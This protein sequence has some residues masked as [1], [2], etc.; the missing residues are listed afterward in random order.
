MLLFTRTLALDFNKGTKDKMKC[1]EVKDLR[2]E[3]EKQNQLFSFHLHTCSSVPLKVPTEC[4]P[5]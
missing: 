2:H 1:T 3:N 4:T 5:K